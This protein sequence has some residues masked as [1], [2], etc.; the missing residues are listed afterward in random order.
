MSI[1]GQM[2]KENVAY[3]Y[4]GILLSLK[5]GNPAICDNMDGPEGHLLSKINQTKKDKY[6]MIL[7][8]CESKLVKE[9]GSG[10]VIARSWMEGK[11][12]R[13]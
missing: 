11:I 2:D 8:I 1:N 6:C 9:A 4:S 3:T 12:R 7:L 10:M 13:Y 5:K